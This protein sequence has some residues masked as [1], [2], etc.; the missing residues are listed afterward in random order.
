MSGGQASGDSDP[1]ANEAW[2]VRAIAGVG[3]K[4]LAGANDFQL[5]AGTTAVA[6]GLA[7]GGYYGLAAAGFTSAATVGVLG[8]S[9]A[10]VNTLSLGLSGATVAFSPTGWNSA[11]FVADTANLAIQATI[12][13]FTGLAR[14]GLQGLDIGI[15]LFQSGQS[16]IAARESFSRGNNVAGTFE[17]IG[18]GFG[19][20]AAGLQ[21]VRALHRSAAIM[22]QAPQISPAWRINEG[23][24]V[25]A[26]TEIPGILARAGVHVPEDVIL[27]V[28]NASDFHGTIEDIFAGRSVLTGMI[29]GIG[30]YG[31]YVQF[32]RMRNRF[33]KIP[34]RINPDMMRSDEAI[35]GVF[36]HE[37][38]ELS[39]FRNAF[40]KGGGR[41]TFERWSGEAMPGNYGNFHDQAWDAADT[42]VRRMRGYQP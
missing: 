17:A 23:G 4:T 22:G 28:G 38:H 24:V 6:A 25:R 8:N 29:P 13:R 35:V 27:S 20:S 18:A 19:I 41:L 39:L 12:G 40:S 37:L 3:G 42:A 15:N 5:F 10:V 30:T 9:L 21:G 32:D 1:N 2:I 26:E 31:R 14:L 7:F 34:I 16:A 11:N 33:G 36:A